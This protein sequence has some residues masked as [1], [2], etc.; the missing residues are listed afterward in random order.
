M[1]RTRIALGLPLVEGNV[2]VAGR[3]RGES[4]RSQE[5]GSEGGRGDVRKSASAEPQVESIQFGADLMLVQK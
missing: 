2:M 4:V 5:G 1:K 3:R